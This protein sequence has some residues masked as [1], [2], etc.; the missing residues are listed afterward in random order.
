M[1]IAFFY[2]SLVLSVIPLAAPSLAPAEL[3]I[4]AGEGG[5][6][7]EDGGGGE[8]DISLGCRVQSVDRVEGFR[9]TLIWSSGAVI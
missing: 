1:T 6:G 8:R 7:G 4:G 3:C 5:N 2:Y 9:R